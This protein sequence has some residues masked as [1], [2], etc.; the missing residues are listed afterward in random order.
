MNTIE[1]STILVVDDDRD[2]VRAV[3]IFL[4][5]EGYHVL[6][7]YDGAA[8][9]EIVNSQPVHLLLLDVMMP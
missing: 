3:T 9:L 4:E 5:N 1:N 2:I 6:A 7:A 8:A